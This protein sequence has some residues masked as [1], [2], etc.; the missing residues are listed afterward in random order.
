MKTTHS[1]FALGLVAA[2]LGTCSPATA[3]VGHDHGDA[4][5]QATGTALPRFAAVSEAFELV[6]VL[7]GKQLTLYL[8]RY[9][10]NAPVRG[11]LIELEI[12]GAK[13]KAE[14]QGGDTYEVVLKEAPKPGVLAITATVT[15]DNEVDLLAGELDLHEQAHTEAP[16]VARSWQVVGGWAAGGLMV[17]ALLVFVGRRLMSPR[18][19]PAGGAA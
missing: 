19:V 14:K 3:G 12:A 10:D 7:N 15:A 18:P 4:G 17:L 16:A 9:A 8:D 13:F 1:L 5:Q 11:A 2:L 6:G